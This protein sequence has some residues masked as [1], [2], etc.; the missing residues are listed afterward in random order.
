MTTATP[1]PRSQAAVANEAIARRLAEPKAPKRSTTSTAI[2][3]TCGWGEFDKSASRAETHARK[4][5]HAVSWT[6][7][8]LWT[9]P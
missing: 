8:Q 7:T 1:R 2:C 4:T 5:G 6:Q 3:R 9:Q